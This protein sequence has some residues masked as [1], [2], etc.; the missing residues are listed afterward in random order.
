MTARLLGVHQDDQPAAIT[1][2]VP[3]SVWGREFVSKAGGGPLPESTTEKQLVDLVLRKVKPHLDS[4]G[5][6]V[7]SIK[8]S[9]PSVFNGNWDSRLTA[10]GAALAGKNV[11]V[12]IWHE[13]EDDLTPNVFVPAHNRA[14]EAIQDGGRGVLVDYAAMAYQW[15]PGSPTTADGG[16]WARD[17]QADR[18]LCD[19]YFGN[20]VPSTA[21]LATHPGL[22]RWLAT[23]VLP[24]GR[25][26]GLGEWG[27]RS[28]S[29][30]AGQF[31]ADFEWLATDPIGKTCSMLLVWNTPGTEKDDRWVLDDAALKAVAAGFARLAVPAGPAGY[32]PAGLDGFVVSERSGCLVAAD[33]TGR[34][35]ELLRAAGL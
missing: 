17:L 22:R 34:H 35:D 11:E 14:R 30:R 29:G 27:R 25:P 24:Y 4:G 10:V 21:T 19:V 9:M 28:D 32:R 7:V 15:R 6:C 1:A 16:E 31:A 3:G 13:P 12:V 5:G 23:M 18:Y 20:S 26:W 2:R 8:I 33:L